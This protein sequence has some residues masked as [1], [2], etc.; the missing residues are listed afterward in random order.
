MGCFG[1]AYCRWK[2]VRVCSTR[3]V[4]SGVLGVNFQLSSSNKFFRNVEVPMMMI[5]RVE[6]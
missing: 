4:M 3:F 1:F 5:P 6:D 2:K